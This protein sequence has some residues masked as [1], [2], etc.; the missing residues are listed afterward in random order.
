MLSRL[1]VLS[2]STNPDA[3]SC[4]GPTRKKG[5]T[6]FSAPLDA[7]SERLPVFLDEV[8][9]NWDKPRRHAAFEI[10]EDMAQERQ[11]FVFTCPPFFAEETAEHID[12]TALRTDGDATMEA[13][14]EDSN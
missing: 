11:L 3:A 1:A 13:R 12:L 14:F 10:L 9:V 4:S 2:P 6:R 7:E 8:F 5:R